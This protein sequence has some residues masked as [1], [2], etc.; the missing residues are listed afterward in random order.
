MIRYGV[1]VNRLGTMVE[2]HKPG[3]QDR[4]RIRTGKLREKG[5][6]K[7]SSSIW[8]EIKAVY[9]RVQE[10]KCCFCE[11]KFEGRYGQYELDLEH[12]RPKRTVKRWSYPQNFSG[13][14][15]ELTTPPAKN[16]GYYLLSYHL[17]NYAAAC[18]PCNSGLKKNY[19]PILGSYDFAATDPRHMG[20]EKALLLYPIGSSDIDPE[21]VISFDGILPRSLSGDP[22]V[23]LRGLATIVFFG[24]DDVIA[25]K[26]LMRERADIVVFLHVLLVKA[27]DHEDPDAAAYVKR[28]VSSAAPHASCARDFKRLFHSDPTQAKKV[29][30]EVWGFRMSMS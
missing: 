29:A 8:S 27:E 11:R 12:F 21:D 24:L 7:E 6:Y 16:S 2:E 3:W 23:R 5:M 4:A 28:L 25:R 22:A 30:D 17:F 10:F 15:T 18:K 1:D 9:M 13:Q 19:F 20:A 26:N 14:Q